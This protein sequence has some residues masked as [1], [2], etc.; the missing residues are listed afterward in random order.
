MGG[1]PFGS[2]DPASAVVPPALLSPSPECG[3]GAGGGLGPSRGSPGS[4]RGGGQDPH[5]ELEPAAL[6]GERVRVD[7]FLQK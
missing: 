6:C 5:V 3:G 4:G 1:L 2:A 7:T